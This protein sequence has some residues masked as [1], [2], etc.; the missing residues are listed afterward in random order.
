LLSDSE[1]TPPLSRPNPVLRQRIELSALRGDG[2]EFPVEITIS[3]QRDDDDRIRRSRCAC[4]PLANRPR[5][6]RSPRHRQA[7]PFALR[8]PRLAARA[9]IDPSERYE[10]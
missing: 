5:S 4:S 9:L 6:C 3:A 2:T 10:D 1:D 8:A 7:Q